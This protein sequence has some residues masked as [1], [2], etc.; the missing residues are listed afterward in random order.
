MC[1][2]V[3]AQ[4]LFIAGEWHRRFRKDMTCYGLIRPARTVP[5]GNLTDGRE[6]ARFV[7]RATGE[8]PGGSGIG[9]RHA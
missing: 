1:S 2:H 6:F 4:L 7:V 9:S 3:V 5:C 8:A